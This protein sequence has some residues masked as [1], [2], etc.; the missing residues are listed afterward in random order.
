MEGEDEARCPIPL[1]R[2]HA[3]ALIVLAIG[4]VLVGTVFAPWFAASNAAAVALF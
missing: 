2:P 1:T 4:V 3:I